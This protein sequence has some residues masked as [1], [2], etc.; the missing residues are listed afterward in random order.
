MSK[1]YGLTGAQQAPPVRGA[2]W[3][4]D[5]IFRRGPMSE[6]T[7][8]PDSRPARLAQGGGD[9]PPPFR[10]GARMAGEI[11]ARWQSR[12]EADGTFNAPNPAGP[13]SGGFDRMAGRP[14]FMIMDMFPY[15]SGAGLHVGH[16][17]GYIATDVYARYLRMTGH[18]VLH[19]FGYDAF[20]LPAEQYAIDTGQHPVM[21]TEHNIATMRRQLRRLGLGHDR[22]RELATTDPGYYKWTQWIFLQIFNSWYDDRAGRARPVADLVAEFASGGR[23][24]MGEANPDGLSWAEL[25]PAQ[26]RQVV[27]GYRLAYIGTELVNWCPGL[28]TVLANEEVTADGRSD[29]GNYPVYRRPLR[30][31]MLR[32]SAYAQRLIDDLDR[33]DWPESVKIMQRNWIGASD[34]AVVDFLTAPDRGP[35]QEPLAPPQGRGGAVRISVFTTR[36]DTLPGATYLVLAPEHPLVD[37]LVASRWPEG[38]PHAWR[39]PQGAPTG[40]GSAEA[41]AAYQADAARLS[42]RQR[43]QEESGKTG[44]FTGS[45]VINSMTGQRIPVFVADYVLMGYGTGAIMAVPAHDDRD[46]AFA[47]AFGLPVRAVLAPPAG[48][49]ASHGV[50][51]G[52]PAHR[53]PAAFTGEGSY[54]DLGIPGLPRAATLRD[55]IDAAAGWLASRGFGQAARSYRL[56]DWLFSRQRYWGEPFPIVYDSTGLPV[57]LPD[58]EL[59]VTLPE[60]TDFRPRPQAD[61]TSEPEPPLA[62]AVDWANPVLDLGDGPRRYRRE[63]NTMPQWAGSCWYYLRYLEPANTAR[64]T[65]EGAERY[66]LVP[67]GAAPGDGGVDLYVGGVE[68]AVLHLLYARFWHK[69]LYDLGQVSTREPFQRLVNQ[70]Y[71]Q[72]DAYLDARGMYVPAADVTAAPG[73]RFSY[74]GAPVTVRAGKMGKSKK[75]AVSPDDIYAAYGADTL[76]LY[77]MAMGPLNTDRPWRTDDIIGVH[78][79]LQ[80]LWRTVIDDHTGA[81]QV[82]DGPLGEATI[83]RLHATIKAVRR[84]LTAMRFH[85]AVARLIELGTHAARVAAAG[86]GVPRALAEPLV[87]MTAPFAPHIAEELWMALGHPRTLAYEPFPEFDEALAGEQMVTMPVQIDSKIRFLVQ[88]PAA[89]Q[90][91]EIV[92]VVTAHPEYARWTQ[93]KAVARLIIVPGRIANVV[94]R[95]PDSQP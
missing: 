36:P 57:A 25:S 18:N 14:K 12:W 13:L 60:M 64:F 70:G 56:R 46:L 2:F 42:D 79:F 32:I 45:Y 58:S 75:N 49:L 55:G 1:G 52:A 47:R 26:R 68:H 94:T 9:K 51:P 38:T 21:T 77:E 92:A 11:E 76:R 50:A 93:G 39:Y 31:W 81:P 54:L 90:R 78:R 27:D 86:P 23:E 35:G 24:P 83:R 19:P 48:W 28:G 87:L 8:R 53:W 65:G 37:Q 20:G 44:V 40:S 43:T 72:A 84:D 15:P 62:R 63:L 71:I 17:L 5:T 61:E 85:T 33:V 34:G 10:Y 67:P 69:V 6:N 80:R 16:P 29:I 88:V 73:G 74:Q 82:T 7:S 4:P 66:W 3:R 30:Q 59:P 41:V 91:D 22:R 95:A 89:A